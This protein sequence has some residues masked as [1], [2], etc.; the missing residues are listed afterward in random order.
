MKKPF[1]YTGEFRSSLDDVVSEIAK[2][3]S[4]LD[5][6]MRTYNRFELDIVLRETLNNAVIHGNQ[7][8]ASHRIKLS[9]KIESDQFHIVVE[10]E[11]S[12][13]NW[14]SVIDEQSNPIVENGRGFPIIQTY[15]NEVILNEKGNRITLK[16]N[17]HKT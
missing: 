11:G 13:F 2:I 8:R 1:K 17:V 12:G 9:L 14:Q 4:I 6:E 10:D 15:C 16:L 7:N 5:G 3:F